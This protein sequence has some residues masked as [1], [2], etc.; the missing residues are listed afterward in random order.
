MKNF[1]CSG[2]KGD[3]IMLLYIIKAMGGGNLYLTKING[4][5]FEGFEEPLEKVDVVVTPEV[6]TRDVK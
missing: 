4:K 3:L 5:A 2:K 1:S 6:D